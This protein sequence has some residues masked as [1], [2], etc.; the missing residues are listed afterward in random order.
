M[1]GHKSYLD[2]PKLVSTRARFGVP[3]ARGHRKW[4]DPRD[5]GRRSESQDAQR[6]G[7][8]DAG[9]AASAASPNPAN[10]PSSGDSE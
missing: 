9:A 4:L 3:L 6:L 5:S 8:Q 1:I 7:P 2:N 10:L